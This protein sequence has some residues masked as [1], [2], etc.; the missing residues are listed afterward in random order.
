[1]AMDYRLERKYSV[2]SCCS[3][4][5]TGLVAIT[6]CSGYVSAPSALAIGFLGALG[7]NF[8]TRI[9]FLLHIDETLDIFAVH[10]IG[11]FI[12]SICNAF[13]AT[14]SVAALDGTVIRGGFIR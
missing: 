11:G 14:A 4:L 13:F 1:M 5:I 3:G 7:A 6:P 2:I 12:G 10:G 9:K 8:G